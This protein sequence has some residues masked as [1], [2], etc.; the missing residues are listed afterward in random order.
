M[1][2][3]LRLP[4]RMAQAAVGVVVDD[5]DTALAISASARFIEA[6]ADAFADLTLQK[7]TAP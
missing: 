5:L 6:W 1:K 4:F 3:L 7:E 2:Y